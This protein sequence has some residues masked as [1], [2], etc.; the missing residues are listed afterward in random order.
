MDH[1]EDVTEVKQ[2]RSCHSDNLKDPEANMRDGEGEVI[3]DVLT[4]GLLSVADEVGL[5][6]APHL[7]DEQ[8]IRN[9]QNVR[10]HIVLYLKRI[11]FSCVG[12]SGLLSTSF[13]PLIGV[14]RH[15]QA[16]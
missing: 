4:A 13:P 11:K 3:A 5:L 1:V 9:T 15:Y 2:L 6:I 10:L 12:S 16:L 14:L 8:M 7:E